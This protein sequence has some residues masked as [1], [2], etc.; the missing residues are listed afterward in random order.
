[1]KKFLKYTGI[2][3]L[4]LIV[5]AF[6][7]PF[8]FKGKIVK[9]VKAEIN[10]NIEA[11]VEFKDVS[12]SLFRHFP[13]LSIGLEDISV[14]GTQEFERD[15]LLSAKRIDAS[16]N[17]WSAI[18]GSDMKVYGV[19]LQ[20]PR[21]HALVNKNGKAN[22]EIT[23]QDTTAS[24]GSGSSAFKIKLEKYSIQDGYVLYKDES[25]NMQMEISGL[26]HEG[27]G[28]ITSDVFTLATK[29]KAVAASFNYEGVP[30]LINAQ[31]GIDADIII[32]NSKSKYSFK[33]AAIEVNKLQLNADGFIQID[34]DSTYSM[35][36]KFG[37]LSNEF[38]NFLSLVPAIYKTD[39]DKI[40]TSGTASF[41]GFVKGSY[42][43]VQLPS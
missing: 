22:W 10:K 18:S 32:D 42:S 24:T 3:F 29:T 1:M 26:D 13:K 12:L 25:S 28:D 7:I 35:D 37:A 38:K 34:N 33:N 41:K 17:L 31:T 15:T 23:K 9:L 4:S 16:V 43:P 21:I 27:S 30:Y 5:I 14:S 40:K 11:K 36:L 19:F 2:V 8:L 20:S 6:F 39:F